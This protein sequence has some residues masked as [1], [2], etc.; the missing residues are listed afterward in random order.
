MLGFEIAGRD[1]DVVGSVTRDDAR[2]PVAVNI[3][4]S[5]SEPVSPSWCFVF[6][7][8]VDGLAAALTE[9]GADIIEEP[10]DSAAG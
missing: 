9:K 3:Y 7:D 10:A 8:D 1:G 4:F 5:R 2:D 6:V